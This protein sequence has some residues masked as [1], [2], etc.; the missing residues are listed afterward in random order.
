MGFTQR[1]RVPFYL[2]QPQFPATNSVFRRANGSLKVMSTVV[3]KTY[4]GKTD[5]MPEA[6]HEA[7]RVALMHDNV[8][9]EGSKLVG[10]VALEGDGY[11]IE[12]TDALPDYPLAPAEF[13][14]QVD[15]Y[16][17][18]NSS[19]FTCEEATQLQLVDDNFGSVA[20]GGSGGGNVF[21]N[22]AIFCEPVTAS[23]TT[24]NTMYLAAPPVITNT[25]ALTFVLKSPL[26]DI[27]GA[28]ILTYRVTCPNGGYDEADV[29]IDIDGSLAGCSAPEN[30]RDTVPP[31]Y[32]FADVTWDENGSPAGGWYWE[33]YDTDNM[34]APVLSGN[35]PLGF[36]RAQMTGLEPCTD[37][38]LFVRS[39]CEAGVNESAF[40]ELTFSTVCEEETCGRYEIGYNSGSPVRDQAEVT[41][42]RCN[43]TYQ[44][45]FITN[46]QVRLAC[47]AQSSPGNPLEINGAYTS[48]TYIEP[49]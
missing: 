22:D 44:T 8:V 18:S 42:L 26:P 1:A 43:G 29:F 37:Y 34:G 14:V 17:F 40:S 46:T 33:V 27:T 24:Y 13:T 16:D 7:L 2:T 10:R 11:P 38:R 47:M 4:V 9:I 19:C 25:G 35:S 15:N 32:N 31:T 39:I 20:E 28:N 12:Y 48:L 41:F 45:I 30:L 49:C 21:I 36:P 6:W 5:W 23:I 3:R